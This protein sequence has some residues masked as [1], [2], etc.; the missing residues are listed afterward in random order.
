MLSVFKSLLSLTPILVVVMVRGVITIR[1]RK[2][3]HKRKAIS[4]AKPASTSLDFW[5]V[6]YRCVGHKQRRIGFQFAV[7]RKD[8]VDIPRQTARTLRS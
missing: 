2:L 5:G 6:S 4:I 1:R 3:L 8:I 7:F